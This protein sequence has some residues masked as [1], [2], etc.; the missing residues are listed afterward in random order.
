MA[1]TAEGKP[2]FRFLPVHTDVQEEGAEAGLAVLLGGLGDPEPRLEQ[3]IGGQRSE[4]LWK[5]LHCLPGALLKQGERGGGGGHGQP[6]A[7]WPL[8]AAAI[9]SP[10]RHVHVPT[11]GACGDNFWRQVLC[12][13]N[14][15]EN[16]EMNHLGS[17]WALQL[18]QLLR[19]E[20]SGQGSQAHRRRPGE[21]RAETRVCGALDSGPPLTPETLR[22]W[23]NPAL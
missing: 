22:A 17:G 23:R 5:S 16:L 13:W 12:R 15:S 8:I 4:A 21:S 19:E 6:E 14:W 3:W 11:L 9:G 2:G 1:G 18:Q 7:Q 20:S 10:Q